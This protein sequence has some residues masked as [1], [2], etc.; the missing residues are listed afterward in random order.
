M[1]SPVVGTPFR[2]HRKLAGIKNLRFH[3]LRHESV[4]RLYEMGNTDQFVSGT[5]GH[6]SH[7]CLDRYAHVEEVGSGVVKLPYFRLDNSLKAARLIMLHDL[8]G[9]FDERHRAACSAFSVR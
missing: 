2:R 5:T 9:I 4:S 6:T 1:Q 8:A 3:D 7:Q